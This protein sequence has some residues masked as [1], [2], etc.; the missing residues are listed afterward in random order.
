MIDRLGVGRRGGAAGVSWAARS[1]TLIVAG[2]CG[3]ASTFASLPVRADWAEV[4]S[5]HFVIY[6]EQ[7]PEALRKFAERLE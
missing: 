6:G 5:D 1:A 7:R 4:S 3:L 2:L